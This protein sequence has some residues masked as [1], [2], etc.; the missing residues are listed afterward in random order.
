MLSPFSRECVALLADHGLFAAVI[1]DAM[2]IHGDCL[3]ALPHLPPVDD[4]LTDPPYSSGGTFR[5]DRTG[6]TTAKYLG[7]ASAALYPEFSGDNRD[8]RS[9]GYWSALWLSACQRI[10]RPGGLIGLFSDWRQLPTTTDAL[11]SGGFVWRGIAVWDKT[12]ATRPVLGRFR[13]QAEYLVWGTNGPRPLGGRCIPGVFR[14]SALAERKQHIAG[15]PTALLADMLALCGNLVLDPFMGSGSTGVAAI[16]TGR[17]FIGVEMNAD[18]FAI[19]CRRLAEAQGIALPDG[20]SPFAA[21]AA[22]EAC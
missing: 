11:Q 12:E 13:N 7:N 8:Q 5:G 3:A 18:Y 6:H 10:L 1:G 21:P 2:L 9:Y 22:K 4:I 17:R 19:A 14:L 15:K 16:N 20:F